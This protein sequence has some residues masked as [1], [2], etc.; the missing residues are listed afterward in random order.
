MLKQTTRILSV[1]GLV[2]TTSA[3]TFAQTPRA[4]ERRAERNER[5][6][7][8]Q[9][10]RADYYSNQA[11][12]QLDPWITRNGIRAAAAAAANANVRVNAA[13]AAGVTV[14]GYGF[15]D[16]SAA[17]DQWFYDYYQV[18]PT[19]YARRTGS[20]GYGAAIRYF[21][22]DNDGV[23]DSYAQYRDSDEDGV[24]DQY[25]RLD[26][27]TNEKDSDD[28]AG[29]SQAKLYRV[30]GSVEAAKKAEVGNEK[31]LVVHVKQSGDKEEAI[32]DLGPADHPG[33]SEVSVDTKITASGTIEMVGD[34]KLLVADTVAI[35]NQEE[36]AVRRS[37]AKPLSGQVVDV[38]KVEVHNAQHYIGVVE[39]GEGRQL[40]DLGPATTY[41]AAIKPSTKVVIHGVPVR[42]HGH[43]V[44]MADQVELDGQTYTVNRT[45]GISF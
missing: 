41:K 40:V 39:T 30:Q 5:Q 9:V 31:H 10:N 43:T 24:Y 1:F 13:P 45:E 26:F 15:R 2:L 23:Y 34:K 33:L 35:G 19:Y 27:T 18:S 42:T 25:D 38:Q 4:V 7:Q 20:D 16:N 28:Y 12:N 29:P 44:V 3:I 17:N 21:D 6:L 11:W 36:F 22:A 32:V 8:R 37:S 14:N